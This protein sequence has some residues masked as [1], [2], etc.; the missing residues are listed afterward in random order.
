MATLPAEAT[1]FEQVH[2]AWSTLVSL[3]TP[4]KPLMEL[5]QQEEILPLLQ[6]AD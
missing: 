6:T 4:R 5:T 3:L 1:E 2:V